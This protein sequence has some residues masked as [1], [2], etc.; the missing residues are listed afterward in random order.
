MAKKQSVNFRD[1]S[2]WLAS[3]EYTP[4]PGLKD[5]I[6][7]DV[8]IVGGGYTGLSTAYFL[9]KAEPGKRVALLEAEVIGFGA[10]GRNAGFSMTK[11]GLIHS[12]TAVR[13]GKEKT[14]EAHEYNCR[15]VDLLRDLVTTLK[16]DCDYEHNG[17]L[18]VSTCKKHQQRMEREYEFVTKKL[19]IGEIEWIDERE[20]KSRVDS[21]IYM[22]GAWWE[23][24]TG[25]LN[26][27]KLA[28]SWKKVIEQMGVQIYE[29]TPVEELARDGRRYSL[30]TPDGTIKA[31]KVVLATNAWSHLFA[32]TKRKQVP[33]W[34]YI[35]LTEPLKKEHFEKIGWKKREGIED[36]RDLVHYYR[37]TA[38]NRI[39]L[40]GRDVGIQSGND[41]PQ[42]KDY[43]EKTFG[44]LKTDLLEMF[45]QLD[46][47]KFT[48][49][50]GG[51][52]SVPLDLAPALG[53]A[54]S[55]DIVYSLGCCGHAV[56][57]THLNGQTIV[58]LLLE[59]KTDRTDA[60]FVNRRTIP[61]P[62]EPL[63]S[64]AAHA[65]RG[66]MRWEDQRH[67]RFTAKF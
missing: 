1:K 46:G 58:D 34:T 5:V 45:P 9:K 67:D 11:F 37:L 64:M 15:A 54:G 65:I 12:I 33:V 29:N 7:V 10:S 60:F 3:R 23:P 66:F 38:D 39:L 14:R 18:M 26:P 36:F 63:R 22:G 52:V 2:F 4:G 24:R 35:V 40:G 57:M 62:P 19:G 43:D 50:W 30:K 42:E 48:H 8:A 49:Q 53:Y 28:W 47:I 27:A 20:L 16:L 56:S 55:K 32:P 6:D 51:P 13:F 61:W 25:I 59:K 44:A 17:F 31:D 41:M 21:P